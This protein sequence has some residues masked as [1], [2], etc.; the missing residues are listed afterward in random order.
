MFSLSFLF[1]QTINFAKPI[2]IDMA[3]KVVNS[4][5]FRAEKG[6]EITLKNLVAVSE[7]N[8]V[9]FYA[10]E[11]S[12]IGYII[13]T[14]DDDL[15]PV[16]AYSF[17]DKLNSNGEFF[18]ILK[19]DISNRTAN[20][21]K[22]P[23][24]K[25]RDNNLRWEELLNGKFSRGGVEYWPEQG[26]TSTGGWLETNWTQN[27]PYNN[28]CPMDP[29]TSSRSYTGCP[30]TAMS[31]ILNFHKTTNNIVFSDDDD[32]YHNYA[33]R[34][35][36]IDNDFAT[37]GFPSFPQLNEYLATLTYNY[38]HHIMP[39]DQDM[40]AL[41][42]ACG[43]A[44]QQV[45]TS[46]GSGTF[47]VIQAYDAY[48]RFGCNTV[49]LLENT[50]SE[51]FSR[52]EQNM[53]D[54]LPAHLAIVDAAWQTGHNIVVDGYNS[55]NFFHVNFGWGGSNNG[56]YLLPDQLPYSLTVIEGLIVDILKEEVVSEQSAEKDI[57]FSI[58]PNP[59]QSMIIISSDNGKNIANYNVRIE[60]TLGQK[61]FQQALNQ[62]QLQIEL[63][64]ICPKGIYFV[65]IIDNL[66]NLVNNEK[67]IHF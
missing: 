18:E 45:F 7:S 25:I 28:M 48:I 46:E 35:F 13:V 20:I 24:E 31:Q 21:D 39:T 61:I 16:I 67:I 17:Q 32:Y 23:I 6:N 55:D 12:P 34:S 1:I 5:I 3:I 36:W 44:A 22:M 62:Q 58:Y 41:N 19:K 11:L 37:I 51:L 57:Q 4:H 50:D 49:S 2:N 15:P 66:G 65:K 30:A 53:K 14:A 33:G 56:W 42:F 29:V 38:Q 52:L 47:G 9:C 8:V 59:T 43:V 10:A 27:A 26:T 63:K 64:N 60:N 54:T 40:A